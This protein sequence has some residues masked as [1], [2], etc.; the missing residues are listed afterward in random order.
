MRFQILSLL[1]EDLQIK[2]KIST[3]FLDQSLTINMSEFVAEEELLHKTGDFATAKDRN[4][5]KSYLKWKYGVF[6]AIWLLSAWHLLT[7]SEKILIEHSIWIDSDHVK[8][9]LRSQV[10]N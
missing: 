6:F 8:S 7:V 9:K 5:G 2:V 3:V 4:E 1:F 10:K